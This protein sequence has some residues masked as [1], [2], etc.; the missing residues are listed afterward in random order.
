[1]KD[2]RYGIVVGLDFTP[3]GDL[4]L[5][6]ALARASERGDVEIHCVHAIDDIEQV[7]GRGATKLERQEDLLE[8]LPR[9]LW[10]HVGKVGRACATLPSQAS[11]HIHVRLGKPAETMMQIAVDYDCDM[12]TIGTHGRTGFDK[13]VLGSVAEELVRKARC[14]VLVAKPRD[15]TTLARTV[16]PDAARPGEP[17]SGPLREMPHY[18]SAQVYDF[19]RRDVNVVGPSMK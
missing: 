8:E 7:F 10:E 12:I 6:E 1:M 2:S 3:A 5:K 19:A 18:H 9:Q 17:L 16:M 14:P 4:A 11:V 15:F 13:W